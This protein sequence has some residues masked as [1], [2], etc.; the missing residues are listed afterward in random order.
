MLAAMVQRGECGL[1]VTPRTTLIG[2]QFFV[3]RFNARKRAVSA[4]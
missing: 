3:P 1:P 2:G 4:A